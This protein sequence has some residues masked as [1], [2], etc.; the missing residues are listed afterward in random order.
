VLPLLREL[1]IGFVAYSPLSHD[2]L[3]RKIRSTEQFDATDFRATNPRFTGEKPIRRT[4]ER[5]HLLMP[6]PV[7][8]SAASSRTRALCPRRRTAGPALR[9][10]CPRRIARTNPLAPLATE[11]NYF[12][13][14]LLNRN[15]PP[16]TRPEVDVLTPT[17]PER[18][19]DV[20]RQGISLLT[21]RL[22]ASWRADITEQ[23]RVSPGS[24]RADAIVDLTA[25]DGSRAAL[26]FEAK[27]SIVVRDL[28]AVLNQLQAVISKLE[29]PTET[30]VP[31][32]A[33][34]YL[35]PSVRQW[36][37]EHQVS[38]VD[39]TGNLRVAVEKPALYLR[40]AGSDR[41]PWR[42]PGRPRATLQGPAAAR[43]VRALVDHLPP[44]TV[45]ELVA[46]SR[47]STGATYRVVE[48]LEREA[49]I[50]RAARGQIVTVHWRRILQRWSE[51]YGFQRSNTVNA[52]LQPRGLEELVHNLRDSMGLPYVLTG[53]LA[54]QRVAP[55]AQPRLAMLY[56]NVAADL[57]GTLGLRTVEGGANVLI[58]ET[59]YDVVFD[60]TVE[61][62]G[63]RFV[64]PSQA[65]VDLLTAPGRGPAEGQALLDWMDTH[66]ADWQR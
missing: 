20:L 28:P 15:A 26:V 13:K 48:F 4:L 10:D 22:P 46:R 31:V 7:S 54:A 6:R 44:A 2:V 5:P 36:L 45:T 39:A 52:Y 23:V 16:T 30:I 58:A 24:R 59:D 56:A 43:V 47:A 60:R 49:L 33:G 17:P 50:E 51:D 14:N 29:R 64:A 32:I 34:R 63:L 41:D 3:T 66:E 1:R 65:A 11:C 61:A 8:H 19:T 40:D 37:Q 27:R 12:P 42:G 35:A 9:E 53:S 25:P 57:V 38:Y 55:Y 21:S 62:D 18:E